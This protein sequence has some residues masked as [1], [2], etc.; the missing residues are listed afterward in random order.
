MM[1]QIIPLHRVAPP[2]GFA[3][4]VS[5]VP[6]LPVPPTRF[7]RICDWLEDTYGGSRGFVWFAGTLLPICIAAFCIGYF[8]IEM[9]R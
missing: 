3:E 1:A 7:Q 6:S 4:P 2:R 8:S 9:F 5:F